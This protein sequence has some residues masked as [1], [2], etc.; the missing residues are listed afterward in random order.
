MHTRYLILKG[1][2]GG[3]GGA[4]GRA[5]EIPNTMPS[6]CFENAWI[7]NIMPRHE[8]MCDQQRLRPYCVNQSPC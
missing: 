4:E 7:K 5:H 3:G 8:I 6:L 2:G 1:G